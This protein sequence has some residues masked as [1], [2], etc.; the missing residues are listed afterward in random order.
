MKITGHIIEVASNG[1]GLT[2]AIQAQTGRADWK[3]IERQTLRIDGTQQNRRAFY[4]GREVSI[5]L[6]PLG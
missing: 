3:P 6:K 1:D 4:I 5:T 2:V